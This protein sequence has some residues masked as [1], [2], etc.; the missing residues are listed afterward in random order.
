[1]DTQRMF[2]IAHRL[3]EVYHSRWTL[4]L[5]SFL[6]IPPR[7]RGSVNWPMNKRIC[8]R[9]LLISQYFHVST[10]IPSTGLTSGIDYKRV[11]FKA[12]E[13]RWYSTSRDVPRGTVG[14]IAH[15]A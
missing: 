8:F 11:G 14:F 1:M 7:D 3:R 12:K 5:I 4:S 9:G 2:E 13:S 10:F 6:V 15:G